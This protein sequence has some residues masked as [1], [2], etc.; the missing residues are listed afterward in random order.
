[1]AG[2]SGGSGQT[3]RL[4]TC[5]KINLMKGCLTAAFLHFKK[6]YANMIVKHILRNHFYLN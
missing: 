1:M 5:E 4:Q 3:K 6:K 2:A